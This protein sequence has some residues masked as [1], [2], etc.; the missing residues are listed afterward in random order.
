VLTARVY[1][2]FAELIQFACVFQFCGSCAQRPKASVTRH[3]ASA[4]GNTYDW[5]FVSFSWDGGD[6]GTCSVHGFFAGTSYCLSCDGYALVSVTTLPLSVL[7]SVFPAE[8]VP[9]DQITLNETFIDP[10]TDSPSNHTVGVN[11]FDFPSG[12]S[13]P[14]L[15]GS[16]Y[17]SGSSGGV[18]LC[19]VPHYPTDGRAHAYSAVIANCTD[20]CVASTVSNLAS[21]PVQLTVGWNTTL[22]LNV[23]NT[24][25]P[26]QYMVGCWLKE[27]SQP[28][29]NRQI[30]LNINDTQL[31]AVTG[32]DGSYSVTRDFPAVN[33]APT[34]Y[35]VTASFSGEDPLSASAT[36]TAPD[37]TS[38]AACTTAQF[39]LKPSS[40]STVLTVTPQS[41]QALQATKSPEEMQKE[42]KDSGWLTVYNEFSWWYPWYRMHFVGKY[43]GTT[44]IDV[45][46]AALP[47]ADT[48]YFPDTTFKGKINEWLGKIA[49]NVFVGLCAT[50]FV[51]WAA[52]NWGLL[53]FGVVL[54][55]YLAYKFANLYLGWGSVESLYISLVSNLFSTAISAWTGL[56]SFLPTSLQALAAGAESIKNV[57]FAFLC[58]L[59]MVP[60]NILL[61]MMAWNRIVELGGV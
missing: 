25:S 7:F 45:G 59:L 36:A 27:G 19:T 10:F 31:I 28:L 15:V 8:F 9:A 55:G 13:N 30:T 40:N 14:Y 51:L 56:C 1:A 12:G 58:K 57:A 52:S 53:G 18:V 43:G 35:T 54:I 24:S 32:S 34:T 41:T 17:A 20:P 44:N 39:S 46:V 48:V 11:F 49:L 6:I 50:D 2:H 3:C 21:S 33:N 29:P 23:W 38:Y 37:G 60:I 5:E 16:G 42:A 4:T 47:F 26:A 22:S 61:L